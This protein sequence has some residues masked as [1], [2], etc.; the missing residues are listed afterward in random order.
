[1]SRR[2]NQLLVV[3]PRKEQQE[4]IHLLVESTALKIYKEKERKERKQE[5]GKRRNWSKIH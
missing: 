2:A 5:K 4:R 1:M 3:I